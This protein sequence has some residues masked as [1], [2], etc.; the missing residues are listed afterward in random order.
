MCT[1]EDIL[2]PSKHPHTGWLRLVDRDIKNPVIAH[3]LLT[4]VEDGRELVVQRYI[5]DRDE[6]VDVPVFTEEELA[7]AGR[8]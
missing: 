3:P 7:E 1:R 4:R 5:A 6:W 8:L 2:D